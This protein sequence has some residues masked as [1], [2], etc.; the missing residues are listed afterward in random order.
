M[1]W[2]CSTVPFLSMKMK[3]ILRPILPLGYCSKLLENSFYTYY[4][5]FHP[6]HSFLNQ[7][8]W[9]LSTS[10]IN[11]S[12]L[13][14]PWPYVPNN[15]LG[16]FPLFKML[17]FSVAMSLCLPSLSW[18]SGLS[19]AFHFCDNGLLKAKSIG[20]LVLWESPGDL[21]QFLCDSPQRSSIASVM[22]TIVMSML[23]PFIYCLMYQA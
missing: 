22:W 15:F 16:I 21:P 19:Y 4:F 23:N 7:L 10:I 1:S 13:D 5:H 11:C 17:K 14:L 9:S 8:I 6:A 18:N 2:G 3:L 20:L 12:P